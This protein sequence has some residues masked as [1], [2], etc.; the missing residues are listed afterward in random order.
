MKHHSQPRSTDDRH[1]QGADGYVFAE[2]DER[3][4][5]DQWSVVHGAPVAG[6][7]EE[8]AA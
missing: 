8:R 5:S 7:L 4:G 3:A 1:A 2:P 6:K